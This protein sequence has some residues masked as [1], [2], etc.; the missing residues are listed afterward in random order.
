MKIRQIDLSDIN[1]DLNAAWSWPAQVKVSVIVL[2]SLLLSLV[3]FYY[4]TL[5]EF[6]QWQQ[7]QREEQP[8]KTLFET[9][10]AQAVDLSSYQTQL[11]RAQ[12]QWQ[13]INTVM[14]T[15]DDA[16]SLLHAISQLGIAHNIEFKSLQ[17]LPKTADNA[18][19]VRP[20]HLEMIGNYS[21]LRHFMA[22]LETF[23]TLI[24]LHDFTLS[25]L[26]NTQ[27]DAS[28][29]LLI[30]SLMIKAYKFNDNDTTQANE[31]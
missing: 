20:I 3:L 22:T 16:S 14:T 30:M 24:T 6:N 25:T 26:D 1:W 11:Q 13:T 4:D 9:N 8:L 29:Q 7:L 27:H 28:N 2:I 17:L 12:K 18:L 23:P 5:N 21:E 31:K 10:Q 19:I 15:E